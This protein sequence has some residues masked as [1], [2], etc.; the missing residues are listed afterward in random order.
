[1]IRL[2]PAGAPYAALRNARPW[3]VIALCLAFVLGPPLSSAR[4][5]EGAQA[6]RVECTGD[7]K[8]LECK[9]LQQLINKEN[10]QLV[11]QLIANYPPD[12]KVPVLMIQL[13]LGLNLSEPVQLKVDSGPVEKQQ[14]QTCTAAGCFVGMTLN[15][16]QLAAMRNGS[17][18]K[19]TMQDSN[20]KS[21][22]LDVPLLGF[23]PA[24]DKTR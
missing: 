14:V 23:G 11:A 20:K 24:L 9:A 13:P 10:K 3:A 2:H 1:M 18:L 22:N 16:K 19:I 5:Q 8:T 7:G 12:G 17:V 15:D 6:W 4:A 21:L